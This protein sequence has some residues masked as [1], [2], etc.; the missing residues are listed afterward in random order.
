[1]TYESRI[2]KDL[3]GNDRIWRRWSDT[4]VTTVVPGPTPNNP[5]VKISW[6]RTDSKSGFEITESFQIDVPP[7]LQLREVLLKADYKALL[8]KVAERRVVYGRRHLVITLESDES[9]FG[10]REAKDKSQQFLAIEDLSCPGFPAEISFV[11][12]PIEYFLNRISKES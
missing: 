7:E 4:G 2:G 11:E 9:R 6:E 3:D 12:I 1:M 8:P 10:I 5:I